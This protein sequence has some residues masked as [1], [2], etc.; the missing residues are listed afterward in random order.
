MAA[1]LSPDEVNNDPGGLLVFV[2]IPKTAGTTLLSVLAHHHRHETVR[3]VMMRGMSWVALRHRLVPAR[4]IS[5]SKIRSLKEV[6]ER[7]QVRLLH[8]HFDLSLGH[9]LPAGA[10]LVTVLRDP[11]ERAISHYYHYRSLTT[12]PAHRLALRVSLADWVSRC[13]LV[14]MDNGQTRR[15]AGEMAL[16]VG[17]VSS[18]TLERAKANLTGRFAVV[19]LTERFEEFLVILHR[20]FAWPYRRYPALNVGAGRVP[21]ARIGDDVLGIVR[22]HNHFDLELYRFAAGMFEQAAGRVNMEHELALLRK[23]PLHRELEHP[24]PP[25]PIPSHAL[26]RAAETALL[27]RGQR[28]APH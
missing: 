26:V 8:G 21:R 14:E 18:R 19:G 24:K 1:K 17:R 4:L 15:L 10:Q 12:D 11:V 22:A 13:G 28:A 3:K 5:A 2:H 23:A 25:E 7:R 27:N 6:L 20:E 16:P 9:L